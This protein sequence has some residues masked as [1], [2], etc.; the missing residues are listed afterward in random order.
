[1]LELPAGSIVR[2][3]LL[4]ALENSDAAVVLISWH[5]ISHALAG[6]GDHAHRLCRTR[7][8]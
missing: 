3:R 2:N 1:M 5:M 4:M 6:K 8:T 7:V